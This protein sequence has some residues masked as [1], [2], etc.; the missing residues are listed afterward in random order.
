M[1]AKKAHPTTADSLKDRFGRALAQKRNTTRTGEP[2]TDR[3]ARVAPGNPVTRKQT[4]R[5]KTG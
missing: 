5:R 2:H 4:F 3:G 1:A